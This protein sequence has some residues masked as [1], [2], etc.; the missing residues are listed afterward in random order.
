MEELE[1]FLVP[2]KEGMKKLE[3]LPSPKESL[4]IEEHEIFPSPPDEL[5]C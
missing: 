3:F 2:I 5:A 1:I 4:D